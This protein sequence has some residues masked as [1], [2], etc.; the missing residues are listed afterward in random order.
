MSI[1]ALHCA[2]GL[3][4]AVVSLLCAISHALA[5]PGVSAQLA[6][7]TRGGIERPEIGLS[8]P[9]GLLG[10]LGS[11]EWVATVNLDVARWH[12][13]AHEHGH[14]HVDDFG[15]TPQLRLLPASRGSCEPFVDLGVGA[16]RLSDHELGEMQLGTNFQF[17]EYLGVGAALGE[18]RRPTVAIRLLH[19]SNR[20]INRSNSGLTAFGVRFEYRLP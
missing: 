1:F 12:A 4:C 7:E 13:T 5:Q 14:S 9:T 19:E 2:K 18:R 20:G 10:Q 16:H 11:A 8:F 6:K 3:A 15:V 17:G